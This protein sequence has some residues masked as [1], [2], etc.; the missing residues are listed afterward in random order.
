MRNPKHQ[1]LAFTE[2]FSEYKILTE[3]DKVRRNTRDD[4]G[5]GDGWYFAGG[6]HASG[7]VWAVVWGLLRAEMRREIEDH[8][9]DGSI[10]AVTVEPDRREH[11]RGTFYLAYVDRRMIASGRYVDTL[12]EVPADVRRLLL[13]EDRD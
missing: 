8:C 12:S 9:C 7:G 4:Y 6:A 3:K 10:G 11:R 13:K 2:V 1:T 5:L